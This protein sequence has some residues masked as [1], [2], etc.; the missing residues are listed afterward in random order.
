[1]PFNVVYSQI[2]AIALKSSNS[3][4]NRLIVYGG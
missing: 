4:R 1:M 3:C 2:K